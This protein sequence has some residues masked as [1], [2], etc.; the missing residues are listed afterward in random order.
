[1]HRVMSPQLFLHFYNLGLYHSISFLFLISTV[2]ISFIFY[3]TVF[4][5]PES[6][7]RNNNYHPLCL[8]HTL[9]DHHNT[10]HSIRQQIHILLVP[11]A[12]LYKSS[13][14]HPA[15]HPALLLYMEIQPSRMLVCHYSKSIL[16]NNLVIHKISSI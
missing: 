2:T 6:K 11:A 10:Q 5:S 13:Y 16:F 9:P 15:K 4:S 8:F 1:M 3:F 12:I 14:S 7:S